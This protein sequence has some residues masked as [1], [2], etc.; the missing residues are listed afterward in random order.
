MYFCKTLPEASE[1]TFPAARK[2]RYILK[3]NLWPIILVNRFLSS[4]VVTHILYRAYAS[5]EA[6]FVQ[7][8]IINVD[9]TGMAFRGRGKCI[10]NF[11][12]RFI[13]KE[14]LAAVCKTGI[15]VGA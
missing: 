4:F 9:K 10:H 2:T 11:D 6:F 5:I 15:L 12:C 14:N 8:Y 7:I 3:I 13:N 1:H